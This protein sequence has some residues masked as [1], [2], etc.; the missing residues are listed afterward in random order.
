MD[1]GYH[2][3]HIRMLDGEV[4][5]IELS[6]AQLS[7]LTDAALY[8]NDWFRWREGDDTWFVNMRN[9]T[10]MLVVPCD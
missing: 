6:D 1:E 3:V 4:L 2:E 7:E 8:G 9:A 5:H 10:S